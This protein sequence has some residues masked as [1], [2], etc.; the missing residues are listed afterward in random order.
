MTVDH[1]DAS[2]CIKCMSRCGA[3]TTDADSHSPKDQTAGAVKEALKLGYV[4]VS[5][6]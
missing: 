4:H 1:T 3:M 6:S 2:R 5:A